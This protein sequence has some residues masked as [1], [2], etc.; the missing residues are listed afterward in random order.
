M[1][2]FLFPISYF[3]Y[4]WAIVLTFTCFAL[5]RFDTEFFFLVLLPPVIFESGYTLNPRRCFET[6]TPSASLPFSGRSCP[7]SWWGSSCT[8]RE[9]RGWR[10]STLYG[11]SILLIPVWAI[12]D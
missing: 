4:I 10:T 12:R 2:F 8:A 9:W 6:S 11:G 1:S 7:R 3:S 5:H